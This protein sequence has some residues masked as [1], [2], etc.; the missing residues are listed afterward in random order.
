MESSLAEAKAPANFQFLRQGYFCLDSKD[1]GL[2]PEA[3]GE[4]N[5]P[6][7]G[8]GVHGVIFHGDGFCFPLGVS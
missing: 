5:L 8:G 4:G 7:S 3:A 6:G 1:S 2:H